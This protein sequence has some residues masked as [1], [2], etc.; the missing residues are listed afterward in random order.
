MP[1]T[2]TAASKKAPPAQGKPL[3]LHGIRITHPERIIFEDGQITKGDVAQHY[4]AI[5]PF[6]LAEIKDRPISLLRCPSGTKAQCFFQR[7]VGFG[8]GPD[9]H[10]FDWTHKGSSY[11]YIFVK[12]ARGIMEMIQMGVIEIHPWGASVA[13]IHTP[14]RMIFDFDPDPAVPFDKVKAAALELRK[15]LKKKGLECELKCTGG[16]GLHV[17]VPLATKYS[18]AEVKAFA[19]QQAQEMVRDNP[20]LYVATMTKAKRIGKIFIDYFRNDYTATAIAAY[21]LRARPGAP[22]A[23]PLEWREL[24]KLKGG[25]VFD[26]HGTLAR[27]KRK[28]PRKTVLRQLLPKEKVDA[29]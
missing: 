4:A 28:K 7:N 20:D 3:I 12:D 25:D 23:V 17:T 10:P 18:W 11:K 15:R 5:A 19:A 14:D 29:R 24:K 1:K 6:L 16:K 2:P 27:M 9:V 26:M 13:K 22:V 21:S 8:L